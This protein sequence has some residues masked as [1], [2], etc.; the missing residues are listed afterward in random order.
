MEKIYL[1]TGAY[2]HL[3]SAIVR[4]LLERGEKVRALVLPHD[5]NPVPAGLQPSARLEIC[6]GD[7]TRSDSLAGF[8]RRTPSEELVAI[9]AAGIVSIASRKQRQVVNV[10]VNGTAN[11]IGW[12]LRSHVKKL[13]YIS[14]VHAI[15]ESAG[16]IVE[17]RDF[18]PDKVSGLYA[19]T[20]AAATKRVLA[21]ARMGLDVTVVHPSGIIGPG[22]YAHSHTVQM[23]I[24]FLEG[25][26]VACVR[27]GYDF[28]DVRDVAAGV[29][30]AERAESGACYILSGRYVPVKTLL[31]K[32]A[33]ISGKK[34]IHVML[35]GWLARSTA[36][37]AE[38][39]YKLLHQPP[40]YTSYSLYTLRTGG[41]FSHQKAARE[42]G[43]HV[44]PLEETLRDTLDFLVRTGRV[45][46]YK[47]SRTQGGR[48][49]RQT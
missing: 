43:Y 31:D 12:C 40:L 39:Y 45:P 49:Q 25:R 14:S 26:L 29:L 8:F 33:E 42:L 37:L 41:R 18:D 32:L 46:K 27:G 1:V 21:A 48:P 7:V 5:P 34:P 38:L 24:D 9:H 36:P 2:G 35:P 28:V 23:M 20:K 10:N 3:G 22:D 47:R 13:I 16:T 30:A 4:Q 44:R 15:P 11:V 17:T 19:K 6:H